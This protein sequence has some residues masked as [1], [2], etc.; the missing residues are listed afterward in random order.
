MT[1]DQNAS[2][3]RRWPAPVALFLLWSCLDTYNPPVTFA[4]EAL[5]VDGFL[6]LSDQSAQVKLSRTQSVQASEPPE[7]V[8]GATVSIQKVDGTT[9]TLSESQPGTYE[10]SNLIVS[11][12]EKYSL[13]ISTVDGKLFRSDLVEG[14]SSPPIESITS[15]LT[16]TGDELAIRVS[17]RNEGGSRYFTWDYVETFEYTA[18][19][20]SGMIN[21]EKGPRPRRPDED[22]YRCWI[23]VPNTSIL[24]GNTQALSENIVRNQSLLSIPRGSPKLSV[25]Y[26]VLVKQRAIPRD[27]YNY[28]SL[29]QKTTEEVGGLFDPSPAQVVGNMHA[30]NSTEPILGYFKAGSVSEKRF[31]VTFEELPKSFQELPK[32][33][34]QVYKT[35]P[36]P[37]PPVRGPGT[38][39]VA[40]SDI[41]EYFPLIAEF[42]LG[43][44]TLYWTYV[45]GECAD[46]RQQG[47]KTDRPSFW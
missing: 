16:L 21:T 30:T 1:H 37:R 5:V 4:S 47:G 3:I 12:G 31:F 34:C 25:R 41:P 20:Y 40:I 10:A 43:Q 33:N 15:G 28:L 7:T 26:S 18:P 27:E 35:C 36:F 17:T 9:F 6:N 13:N 11:V 38:T 29:L 45:S 24:V 22:F 46:C 32:S 8:A 42:M 14:L 19:T 2:K 23:S 44:D 39:C